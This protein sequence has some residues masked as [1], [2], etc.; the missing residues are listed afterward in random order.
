MLALGVDTTT[1]W[2]S[3]GLRRGQTPLG[4]V[5]CARRS[6]QDDPLL[7][8]LDRLLE[9]AGTHK[10]ELELIAVA[11][12]PGSFTGLRV[13]LSLAKG[14]SLGLGRPV[15]GVPSLPLLAARFDVPGTVCALV[16]DRDDRAYAAWFV[17]GE[18]RGAPHVYGPEALARALQ[19]EP[20]P[21]WLIGAM[22]AAV[23]R[24]L[25]ASRD[26]YRVSEAAGRPSGLAVA[27]AGWQRYEQHGADDL[28][29]LEPLYGSPPA[30][31]RPRGD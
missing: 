14:L 3:L 21:V 9:A 31:T 26:V 2:C 27:R 23:Q 29:S 17:D 22:A 4:E 12:G 30:I 1:A 8:A 18:A 13:G 5:A 20:D 28:A 16:S 11:L 15:V 6:R 7:P 10:R 24:A 25:G 19:D